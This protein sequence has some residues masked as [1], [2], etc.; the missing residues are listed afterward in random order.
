MWPTE[1]SSRPSPRCRLRLCRATPMPATTRYQQLMWGQAVP[2]L[3]AARSWP[4]L[5]QR[6]EAWGGAPPA[7][8]MS[9]AAAEKNNAA[10]TGLAARRPVSLTTR[11][12]KD[13]MHREE[14][15][16]RS[17]G[18]CRCSGRC[19]HRSRRKSC[20]PWRSWRPRHRG[21]RRPWPRG[22]RSARHPC[23]ALVSGCVGR[24]RERIDARA[25]RASWRV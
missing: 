12:F 1:R 2:L 4:G 25:H 21:A 16:W 15:L 20:C 6:G 18:R 11:F 24:R 17:P 13:M 10:M 3:G 7:T 9:S 19:A 5:L 22:A 8:V 23:S 14:R